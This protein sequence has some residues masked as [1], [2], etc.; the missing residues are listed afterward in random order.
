MFSNSKPKKNI[1]DESS[2]FVPFDT[3]YPDKNEMSREQIAFFNFFKRQ[4]NKSIKV[5][6]FGNKSYPYLLAYECLNELTYR[7]K[8][9]IND[10]V[11]QLNQLEAF[12]EYLDLSWWIGDI[13]CLQGN[14]AEA[15]SIYKLNPKYTQTHAAN[16]ILNIKYYLNLS[17]AAP[18][19]LCTRK[20]VTKFGQDNFDK[21][22]D[23]VNQ[24]LKQEAT[25]K[26]QD[27][28]TYISKKYK[29]E[30]KYGFSLFSGYPGGYNLLQKFDAGISS[31][32][33]FCYYA[34][35]E[36]FTYCMDISRNAENLLREDLSLPKVGEGWITETELFYK[37]KT[38]FPTYK[39]VQHA[40][41]TWLGR[42]H[43]DV[44]IPEIEVA[45]EYHGRQ[46]FEPVAFFGG[47][48]AFEETQKRD[49][50]KKAKCKRNNVTLIELSEGYNISEVIEAIKV[51]E[52]SRK[53]TIN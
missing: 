44:F 21:M 25:L 4:I 45:I 24:V 40:S 15:L 28:L 39:V 3:Y 30:R 13:H 53:K 7:G 32:K 27:L 11:Y 12:Y 41:P 42:Q 52:A 50:V 34:I 47:Q 8:S 31:I 29:A 6:I 26:G 20:K 22:V 10:A 51:E 1:L 43:L 17:I 36:F 18:E 9:G 23:F 38:H 33:T 2:Q 14:F 48:K 5:E 35:P 46:H 37:I 16:H 49:K 19:I